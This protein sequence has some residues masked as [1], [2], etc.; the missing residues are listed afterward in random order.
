M[1]DNLKPVLN[2]QELFEFLRYEEGI[3]VSRRAVK[4]AVLRRE[5]VPTRIGNSNRF[6]KQDAW[7]W[8]ASRRQPGVYVA[9]T[10][11]RGSVK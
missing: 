1:D 9:S 8:L 10:R 3:P 6:S 4:H 2:E 7:D 5:I 11:E